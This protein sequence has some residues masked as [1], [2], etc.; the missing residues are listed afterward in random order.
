MDTDPSSIC[1]DELEDNLFL[2][3]DE[4]DLPPGFGEAEASSVAQVPPPPPPLP[5]QSPGNKLLS[6]MVGV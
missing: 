5:I 2:S 4:L 6:S 1:D 3:G